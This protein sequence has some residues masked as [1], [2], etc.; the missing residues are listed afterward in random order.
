MHPYKR[1]PRIAALREQ[2]GLT[3][4]EL[5]QRVGVTETTIANWEK[6][7]SGIEWIERIIRLCSELKCELEDLIVYL[8]QT[9]L[10]I[11]EKEEELTFTQLRELIGT[12]EPPS[13]N[14]LVPEFS[15]KKTKANC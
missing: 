13:R 10:G 9:E 4:L 15:K 14:Q 3:Q 11:E 12:N 6:G 5:S 7:R 1:K 8:P 2:A